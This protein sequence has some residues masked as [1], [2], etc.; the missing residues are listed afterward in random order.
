MPVLF[1]KIDSQIKMFYFIRQWEK[2]RLTVLMSRYNIDLITTDICK[3]IGFVYNNPIG[4]ANGCECRIYIS[5]SHFIILSGL[6]QCPYKI[7]FL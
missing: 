3:I 4:S 1:I 6:N 7:P 2:R 5:D